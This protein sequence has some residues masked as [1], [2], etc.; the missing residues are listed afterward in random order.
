VIYGEKNNWDGDEAVGGS[1]NSNSGHIQD[2][3]SD[4]TKINTK[5]SITH[6]QTFHVGK[7]YISEAIIMG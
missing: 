1:C 5:F 6:A 3:G 7:D 4:V 2:L